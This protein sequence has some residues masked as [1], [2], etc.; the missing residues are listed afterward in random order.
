M[1]PQTPDATSPFTLSKWQPEP[2]AE[3]DTDADRS[4]DDYGMWRHMEG[5][6]VDHQAE[7]TM[8]DAADKR[9]TAVSALGGVKTLLRPSYLLPVI[10]SASLLVALLA[11]GNVTRVTGIM[12]L[13]QPSYL[14]PILLLLVAYEAV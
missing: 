10:L 11:F 6:D 14:L 12:R 5:I 7:S 1:T 2:G 4:S 3:D 13:F 9:A 8:I